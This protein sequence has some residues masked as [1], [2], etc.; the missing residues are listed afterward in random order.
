MAPPIYARGIARIVALTETGEKHVGMAIVVDDRHVM[1][2]CHVLNDALNAVRSEKRDRL[3]PTRP[4]EGTRFEVRFPFAANA[5]GDGVVVEWGLELESPKDVAVL[6][7]KP[8]AP[9]EAD[10]AEFSRADVPLNKAWLCNGWSTEGIERGAGGT[11]GPILSN[12]ELQLNGPSGVAV[13]IAE[14]YSGAG[15]WSGDLRAFVGMVVT[16]DRDQFENG[17]AYAVPTEVFLEVRPNLSLAPIPLS[18]PTLMRPGLLRYVLDRW[19]PQ[20]HG[21]LTNVACTRFPEPSERPALQYALAKLAAEINN[22]FHEK[23][24][25]PVWVRGVPERNGRERTSRDPFV[26]PIHQVILQLAGRPRP[27]GDSASANIEVLSR[28]SRVVRNVLRTLD[29]AQSPLI[30]LGEPGS[31]KTMTLQQAARDLAIREKERVFPRLVLYVRLG[32]FHVEDPVTPEDVWAH[33]QK[34]AAPAVRGLLESLAH[35]KRLAIFFDGMD[36][37][38]RD[39]Y[40]AHTEALSLFAGSTSAKT[41]FSCRITDFSKKFLHQRL[42]ILPFNRN[43]VASYLRIYVDS[44]PISVSGRLLTLRQLA[45]LIS[46]GDLPIDP[47]NPFVLWLLCIYLQE[48]QAW[49]SSRVELLQFYNEQNYGRK[50]EKYGS[51]EG[52]AAFPAMRTAFHHWSMFAYVITNRNRGT[53]IPI[54]E[55]DQESHGADVAKMIEVGRLCGVLETSREGEAPLVR[56]VHHRFQE[57]F[58]AAYIHNVRPVISW[59]DKFDAPRW[60]ETMVNLVLMEDGGEAVQAL[61]ASVRELLR[62]HQAA[63]EAP[64]AAKTDGPESQGQQDPPASP[65]APAAIP[66]PVPPPSEEQ[67]TTLA[68]RVELASRILRECGTGGAAVR[69]A[70]ASSVWPA[71]K[72]LADRGNPITQVKMLRACRNL[73][74]ADTIGVLQKPLLSPVKWVRDQAL[75]VIAESRAGARAVGTDLATEIAYDLASGHFPARLR[76]YL[77]AAARTSGLTA[78]WCVGMGLCCYLA[79]LGI[80]FAIAWVLYLGAEQL[81][82]WLA[83]SFWM[84]GYG[85]VVLLASGMALKYEPAKVWIAILG[86]AGA[87]LLLVAVIPMCWAIAS[88]VILATLAYYFAWLGRFLGPP[89]GALVTMVGAIVG[90]TSQ[91]GTLAIFL[92]VTSPCRENR[93]TVMPSLAVAWEEGG[94]AEAWDYVTEQFGR[95]IGCLLLGLALIPVCG[96]AIAVIGLG[97]ELVDR[98]QLSRDRVITTLSVLVTFILLGFAIRALRQSI[99]EG[100]VGPVVRFLRTGTIWVGIILCFVSGVVVIIW[101]GIAAAWLDEI[102]AGPYIIRGL[103]ATFIVGATVVLVACLVIL[104]RSLAVIIFPHPKPYPPGSFTPTEWKQRLAQSDT[105]DQKDLLL[106]TNHETV[107]L[108]PPDF[109]ELLK[110][111][112]PLIKEDPAAST[113]WTQR[114]KLQDVLR[115]ERQG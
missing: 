100:N 23:L 69:S 9:A 63:V 52:K 28:R 29:H 25:I 104:L 18:S 87:T 43:Q 96:L 92:L 51:T 14:G 93:R 24:Y 7:L 67:E 82:P 42:V 34:A 47:S 108:L 48:K 98:F 90:T 60:Q 59:L 66:A 2:C 64:A 33:V 80:L 16:K 56:F 81:V 71:V 8:G 114:D 109:L 19:L 30:L 101:L 53:A 78:W 55:L 89:I 50:Q 4:P 86:T 107:G 94:F 65:T 5:K 95:G 1:T 83:N 73:P 68:D 105:E 26:A 27:G 115:Q 6:E 36:E 58:T 13:R 112:K 57:F 54:D 31:G 12:G 61:A 72:H 11:F 70:L 97:G 10:V 62:A 85:A 74:D 44:F 103:V 49:P 35:R 3:D 76:A 39:R 17:L 102:G 79:N 106:R 75:L 88:M 32:E 22:E 111:V 110:E 77:R 84:A 37:M 15:V 41:L 40:G 45:W 99:A 38:S 21:F 46:K 20:L 91:F 113:Y